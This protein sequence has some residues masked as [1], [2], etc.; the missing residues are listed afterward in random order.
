MEVVVEVVLELFGEVLLGYAT[1]GAI[2]GWLSLF[3]FPH[4]RLSDPSLRLAWLFAAPV[5]GGLAMSVMRGLLK[6]QEALVR[7]WPVLYG[8]AFV[9]AVNLVR[10]ALCR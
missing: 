9:G 1:R 10:Y 8:G 7:L 3:P 6:R 5:V 4:H 2:L